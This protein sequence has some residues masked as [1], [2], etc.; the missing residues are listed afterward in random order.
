VAWVFWSGLPELVPG[1]PNPGKAE[2]R[3]EVL[4]KKR[5]EAA[6]FFLQSGAYDRYWRSRYV[7]VG[8]CLERAW[9]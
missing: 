8:L 6:F 7:G 5:Y 3:T 1:H 2:N 4:S 9:L